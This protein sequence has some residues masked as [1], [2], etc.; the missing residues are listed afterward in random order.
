MVCYNDIMSKISHEY[1]YKL[2]FKKFE[3]EK[4][5]E[6]RNEFG[7]MPCEEEEEEEINK[8]DLYNIKIRYPT[9][10]SVF[11]KLLKK[12][13]VK[14]EEKL[15]FKNE[16]KKQEDFDDEIDYQKQIMFWMSNGFVYKEAIDTHSFSEMYHNVRLKGRKRFNEV[17]NVNQNVF[18]LNVTMPT[19]PLAHMDTRRFPNRKDRIPNNENNMNNYENNRKRNINHSWKQ[20]EQ[21]QNIY[22]SKINQR[23]VS[24][25]GVPNPFKP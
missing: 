1:K 15:N 10:S 5:T 25:F 17:D 9:F 22:R 16:T 18:E 6:T 8:E 24:N 4:Y 19:Q 7:S 12:S 23:N 3:P 13:T 21:R 11:A 2:L 20:N 14:S